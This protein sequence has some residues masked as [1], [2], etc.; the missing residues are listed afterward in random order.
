MIND[1]R[2]FGAAAMLMGLLALYAL[3]SRVVGQPVFDPVFESLLFYLPLAMLASY[4]LFLK[5][6]KSPR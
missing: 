2:S 4:W 1:A 3:V 6:K 5:T